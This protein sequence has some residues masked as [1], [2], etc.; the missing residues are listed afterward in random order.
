MDPFRIETP[1]AR[2]ADTARH[3]LQSGEDLFCE[4]FMILLLEGDISGHPCLIP[5]C[6]TVAVDTDSRESMQ[7]AARRTPTPASVITPHQRWGLFRTF[8]NNLI[9]LVLFVHEL[10][11]TDRA[12]VEHY[13]IKIAHFPS[14]SGT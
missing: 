8:H 7:V 6:A 5:C 13:G 9:A 12:R 2:A 4:N 1:P 11:S 3:V 14:P 10:Y